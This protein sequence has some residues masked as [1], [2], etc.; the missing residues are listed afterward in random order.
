MKVS[1]FITCLADN[2][3]PEVGESVVR[4]LNKLDVEVDFPAGQ[5]CCGQ[6]AFNSGYKKEAIDVAKHTIEVFENS[7]YVILPSGS[8]TGMVHHYYP[9]LFKDEPVWQERANDLINR[10]YEFTQFLVNVLKVDDIGARFEKKVTYHSSC[11]MSR[12]LGVKDEPITLLKNV[13]G[14]E[15]VELPYSYDCCGFGGTFAM[16]MPDISVAMVNEKVEHVLSTDAEVLVS[17]DMGCLMNIGGRMNRLGQEMG[18][19]HIAQVL[20]EG[21]RT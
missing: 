15:L 18:I 20:D 4:V 17:A 2:M 11:H 10:T 8:C 21:V 16:K 1:L 12:L 5:T 7:E 6:P 13:S 3:F 19:M 9:E 14:V